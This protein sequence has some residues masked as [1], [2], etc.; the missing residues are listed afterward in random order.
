[1]DKYLTVN[2][3]KWNAVTPIHAA[4][5]FYDLP[6]FKAGRSTL[7]D[8]ERAEVGDVSNQ[9]LLHLQCHFGM[10][11]LSWARLG[12]H[13]TGV[14]FADAAIAQAQA[15]AQ[16]LN[17]SARFLCSNIYSL[18][19]HL[20][21]QFD[22]VY[23][24]QGVLCWLPDLTQWAR[25]VA[26]FVRPGGFFYIHEFHPVGLFYQPGGMVSASLQEYY[27]HRDTPN[28]YT[29]PGTYAD[30]NADICMTAYEWSYSAGDVV[31][32]LAAA[33]LRI[34]FLHEFD[35]CAYPATAALVKR[36]DG[37]WYYPDNTSGLPLMFSIRARK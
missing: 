36:D 11:T 16:E 2:Q 24:S 12:A 15:L 18:P 34:E 5:A 26:H 29:E 25:I 8:I 21:E 6:A 22:I 32:A 19:E 35:H 14:D 1:M 7:Y 20:N 28:C 37:F 33:G 3:A 13:V 17:I 31:T 9:R 27:A 4:S 23:T 10:D 30:L